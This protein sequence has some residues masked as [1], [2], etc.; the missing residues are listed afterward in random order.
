MA[1]WRTSPVSRLQRIPTATR[2]EFRAR[3]PVRRLTPSRSARSVNVFVNGR[4]EGA[5]RAFHQIRL[6]EAVEI[7]VED[8]VHVAGLL[9]RAQILDELIRLHHVVANLA[10]ERDMLLRNY[11]MQPYQLVKDLRTKEQTGD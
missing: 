3:D 6:D 7:A 9:L 10:A 1:R 8:A 5:A 4:R 11:V 2:N